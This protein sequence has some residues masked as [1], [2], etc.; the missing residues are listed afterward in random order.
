MDHEYLIVIN[1]EGRIYNKYFYGINM[2]VASYLSTYV[3]RWTLANAMCRP[4]RKNNDYQEV[5]RSA[6]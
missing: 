4:I 6:A 1:S 2:H 3:G 5:L